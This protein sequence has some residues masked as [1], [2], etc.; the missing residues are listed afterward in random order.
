MIGTLSRFIVD[1]GQREFQF[2]TELDLVTSCC[3]AASASNARPGCA[4]TT[5]RCDPPVYTRG[6]RGSGRATNPISPWRLHGTSEHWESY[7]RGALVSCPMGLEPNYTGEVRDAWVTFFATLPDGARV[8]DVGT[9]NG[10]VALIARETAGTLGRRF[11]VH[12]VDLAQIDPTRHVKNG[13]VLPAG[14]HVHSWAFLR[15]S[16]RSTRISSTR[17]A[18]STRSSTRIGRGRWRAVPR[19]EVRAGGR[20]SCCIIVTRSSCAT[21]KSRC[22]MRRWCWMKTK[23]FRLLRRY[24]EAE[25]TSPGT[26]NGPWQ[27]LVAAELAAGRGARL[28]GTTA[29]PEHRGCAAANLRAAR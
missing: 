16:C 4:A 14:H 24:L 20:S 23:V 19:A 28:T 13:E 25:R 11:E 18:G 12:G 10:A 1:Y 29:A 8:L 2:K 6:L 22:A 26:A 3:A 21:P 7:Y 17:S 9:G 15:S 5:E 27:E